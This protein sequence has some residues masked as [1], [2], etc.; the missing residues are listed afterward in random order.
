[1]KASNVPA[2]LSYVTNGNVFLNRCNAGGANDI[3]SDQIK[4]PVQTVMLGKVFSVN[5]AA[6]GPWN[7]ATGT[8]TFNWST[9]PASGDALSKYFSA[10]HGGII[11]VVMF[12][13]SGKGLSA[14]ADCGPTSSFLPGP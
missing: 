12:D 2:G 11:N 7:N 13:G 14:T 5:S 3:A 1:M 10:N 4:S 8:T 6:A 9:T